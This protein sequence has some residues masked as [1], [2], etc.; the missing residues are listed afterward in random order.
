MSPEVIY[1]TVEVVCP[2]SSMTQTEG[3]KEAAQ[4]IPTATWG[5]HYDQRAED[6]K[7][8]LCLQMGLID[9]RMK[10]E[11]GSSTTQERS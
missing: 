7:P 2:K 5:I 11:N 8:P 4:L 9:M 1:Y 6:K 10:A 3:L